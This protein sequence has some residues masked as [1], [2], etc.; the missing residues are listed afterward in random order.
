MA[1]KCTTRARASTD[2]IVVHCSATQAKADIGAADIDRWHRG[3]GWQCIG[4][5]YV[6]RRTGLI[7]E[8]R[9]E[10][11]IGSHVKNHNA[12]SIG[13][14]MIGGVAADGKTAEDNFTTEQFASLKALVARLKTKYQNVV[15]QGHRDFP[16]VAK[17]CPSFSVKDWL[18]ANGI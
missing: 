4:Y 10:D 14:C 18:K 5:H 16:V 3:Q 8:G 15:V 1:Y 6:I 7:E 11:K 12:N 13:I 17:A 9:E 2:F